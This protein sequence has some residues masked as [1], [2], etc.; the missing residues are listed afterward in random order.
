MNHK[1]SSE[2]L[3][4]FATTTLRP[5]QTGRETGEQVKGFYTEAVAILT[6]HLVS[7]TNYVLLCP[8]I[9]SSV[10]SNRAGIESPYARVAP[11]DC[12]PR[13]ESLAAWCDGLIDNCVLGLFHGSVQVLEFVATRSKAI[14]DLDQDMTAVHDS[15]SEH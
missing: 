3:A 6:A 1:R 7:L 9:A 11:P 8:N 2:V 13:R 12:D 14:P 15:E 10:Q 5:H 4:G